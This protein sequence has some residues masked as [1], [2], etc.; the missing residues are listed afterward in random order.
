LSL[1]RHKKTGRVGWL[2]WWPP[3]PRP[4][5]NLDGLAAQPDSPVLIVAGEKCADA[6]I[7]SVFSYVTTTWSGGEGQAGHSKWDALKERP[8]P[9]VIWPDCDAAGAR[10]AFEVAEIL[11]ADRV[12]IILPKP[13]WPRK[14]D[15]ADLIRDGATTDQLEAIINS[16]VDVETFTAEALKRWPELVKASQPAKPSQPDSESD[17][18]RIY[19]R[20]AQL[21]TELHKK[22]WVAAE[23]ALQAAIA[24]NPKTSKKTS[25]SPIG[26]RLR[27]KT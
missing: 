19:V 4:L 10:A 15:I 20:D 12:R 9:K 18:G 23:E 16:A 8:T 21:I 1:W 2:W 5:Y 27:L 3:D 11:G 13:E 6:G 7:R 22:L 14:Y 24:E 17:D 25:T 26:T